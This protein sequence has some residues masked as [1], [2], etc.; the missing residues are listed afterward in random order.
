MKIFISSSGKQ[1][2]AVAHTLC[3]WLRIV[4]PDS[5][6]SI[7]AADLPVGTSWFTSLMQKLESM[8]F[9]II[10][11]TPDN[12]RSPW[13]YFEAGVVAATNRDVKVCGFLTGLNSSQI[14]GPLS[15]FQC[16]QS[17]VDGVLSL[18][19]AIYDSSLN[20]VYDEDLVTSVFTANWPR[21]RENLKEALMLYDPRFSTAEV[22]TE[23]SRSEYKLSNEASQ[24]I[25]EAAADKNGLILMA[26]TMSGLILRTNERQ[27]SERHDPRSEV[28]W[29]RA[30]RELVQQGLIVGRGNKGEVFNVTAEGFRVA[31]ELKT[32]AL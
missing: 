21:L 26:R 31:D 9:C 12:V 14:T 18:L 24:L 29:Q 23:Q 10:C 11:L 8:E 1:G 5:H 19:K 32:K 20:G 27:F 30:I 22:E 7:F 13:L 6:P 4:I 16:F 28:N 17:D 2:Q 15:Q 3:E 25:V